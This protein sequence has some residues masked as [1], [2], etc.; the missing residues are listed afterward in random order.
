[1][2][3]MPRAAR[4]ARPRSEPA[5]VLEDVDVLL[6]VHLA[7]AVAVRLGEDALQLALAQLGVVQLPARN[8]TA[9]DARAVPIRC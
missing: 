2:R 7:V 5:R 6:P 1:M 3:A 9:S 4:R 8:K